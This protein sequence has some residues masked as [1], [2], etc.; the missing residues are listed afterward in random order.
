MTFYGRAFAP[1]AEVGG[2]IPSPKTETLT[3]FVPPFKEWKG[4]YVPF[5]ALLGYIGTATSEGMKWRM[6]ALSDI[7]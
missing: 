1:S 7:H 5:N 2:S 6:I 4:I 3:P